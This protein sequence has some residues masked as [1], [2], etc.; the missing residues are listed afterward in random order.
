MVVSSIETGAVYWRKDKE[1]ALDRFKTS[2]KILFE[3]LSQFDD[4][5]AADRVANAFSDSFGAT[6]KFLDFVMTFRPARP[7]PRV[8]W[9][10]IDWSEKPFDEILGL[11]Y[12]YRSRALH[13]GR[14]FPAPMCL[15]PEFRGAAAMT[16]KPHGD[17]SMGAGVL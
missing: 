2:N 11:I 3:Y 14:P 5:K 12:S 9:A 13:E 6:K 1:P 10:S 17:A 4:G 7:I 15:P 8:E 16:E